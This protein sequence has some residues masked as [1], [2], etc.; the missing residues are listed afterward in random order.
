MVTAAP[1][2]NHAGGGL[3]IGWVG[4]CRAYVVQA[5]T[6]RQV[7]EDHTEGEQMRRSDNEWIREL[8]PRHDHIVTRSVLRDEPIASVRITGHVQRVLLCT[9]GMSKVLPAAD[10]AHILTSSASAPRI[11]RSLLHATRA[12]R[13]ASDNIAITVLVAVG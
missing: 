4:D 8:A 5:G 9:D 13:W 6:L 11:A 3:D 12:R 2:A 7:T 10:I 1:M